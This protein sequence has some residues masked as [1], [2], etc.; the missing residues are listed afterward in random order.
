MRYHPIFIHY[1]LIVGTYSAQIISQVDQTVHEVLASLKIKVYSGF[2]FES[3]IV[4]DMNKVTHV[5]FISH[6]TK[7]HLECAALFYYGKKGIDVN[8]FTGTLT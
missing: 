7:I 2:Y 8:A 5:D 3:W 4:G 6:F 1:S